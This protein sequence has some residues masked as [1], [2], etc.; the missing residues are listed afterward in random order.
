[1][2]DHLL[3]VIREEHLAEQLYH[4]LVGLEIE[5]HRI[6]QHGRLSQRPHPRQLGSRTIHPYLQTDFTESQL[7]VIT[8]PNPNI[9]GTLDQL[10]TLQT[11]AYRSLAGDDRIWPLSMPPKLDETDLQFVRNHF[12]RPAIKPYREHLIHKYGLKHGCMTG[13][14]VNYSLP[15]PV[16]NR[17][18]SHYTQEFPTLVAFKN[19]LYF[20]LAQNFVRYQWLLT[21]LFGASPIAEAGFFDPVPAELQHP[22]RSIR[23]SRFG[24][25]NLPQEQVGYE[26]LPGHLAQLQAMIDA[27]TYFSAH[28]FYG[29]VRLKGQNSA[30]NF[31]TG[32]IRYLELRDFDN[33]PF[34]PNG[35]SRHAL[36]FLKFFMTYLLTQPLPENIAT[37]LATA[38]LKNQTVALEDPLQATQYQAEGEQIFA[39]M[40]EM[41]KQLNAHT[42]QW[43]NIDDLEEVL[44]HPEL[45]PA[46]KLVAKMHEGSL[47][48]FG[49]A[50]ARQWY[51]ERISAPTLLPRLTQVTAATQRFV[52][53]ALQAGVR[54]YQVRDED[55]ADLLMFTFAGVTQ[56][57]QERDM[58]VG[59]PNQRLHE[60]F[61]DLPSGDQGV[62][63]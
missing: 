28:E 32:G 9:G 19:A 42:E 27:G 17:L 8:D 52:M 20:R 30:Q 25:V 57:L 47:M 39:A 23:N 61:P 7:E 18:Y 31:L 16:I 36:Y 56:V 63:V 58:Q 43:E 44:M 21:Y 14:H 5:E 6:D 4:S 50:V 59:D 38:R 29:P 13:V 54:F 3:T 1:M 45:T 60:L 35:V 55:G 10:D 12:E 51:H 40:R 2:L 62:I 33:T 41:A 15:D 53:A 26:S 48:K 46:A 34:T 11:V 22:V 37:A 24:F 49:Q